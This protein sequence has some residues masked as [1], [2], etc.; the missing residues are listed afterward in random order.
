RNKTVLFSSHILQEVEALCDR[1]IIINQGNIVADD[2]LANLQRGKKE[3]HL[4]TISFKENA[5]RDIFS[6]LT[7]ITRIEY[8]QPPHGGVD[9]KLETASPEIVRKQLVD[10]AMTHN[11]NIVSLQTQTSSLEEIFRALTTD[12]PA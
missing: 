11:L 8:L 10:L 9:L 2:T 6:Q 4:V 5:G 1:V 12:P 3:T 7:G